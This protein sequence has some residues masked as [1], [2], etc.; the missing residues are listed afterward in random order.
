MGTVE[1]M[2]D[3]FGRKCRFALAVFTILVGFSVMWGS[4]VGGARK[5]SAFDEAAAKAITINASLP[6]R[7]NNG[8]LVVA[9]GVLSSDET[10]GDEYILPGKYIVLRRRVE[11]YQWREVKG[12]EGVNYELGWYEGEND[13]FKFQVQAGHEN[14]LLKILPEKKRVSSVRFSGFDG[15]TITD[16]IGT[17][18]PLTLD[19][20]VLVDK[21]AELNDNKQLIRRS[22]VA[23]PPSLGD[24]RLSYEVLPQGDYTIV[25]VQDNE[26]T[27][28]GKES[29]GELII[30]KG[31]ASA[32]ELLEEASSQAEKGFGSLLLIGAAVLF[33]GLVSVLSPIAS[34][35]DLGPSVNVQGRLAVILLSFAITAVITCVFGLLVLVG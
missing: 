35:I 23:G 4:S 3:S 25:A 2:I 26:T 7:A 28:L 14:P 11:M 10:L 16:S 32:Q 13:S 18:T 20:G 34:K 27:L 6:D 19:P 15:T 5:K 24:M 30:A 22:S 17:L 21:G 9:E 1:G 33:V 29:R 31:K 8:Q 12:S